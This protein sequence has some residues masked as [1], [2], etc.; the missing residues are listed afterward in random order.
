MVRYTGVQIERIKQFLRDNVYSYYADR[1]NL[2]AYVVVSDDPID[3][4]TLKD[5]K[6]SEIDVGTAWGKQW[7]SAWFK[8]VGKIPHEWKNR[9]IVAVID[10]GSEACLFDDKGNP[11]LGLTSQLHV[12]DP[13]FRKAMI[14]LRNDTL[15]GDKVS[16]LVEAAANSI[17]GIQKQAVFKEAIISTF[18]R[19][20][21]N[22]Y[23]DIFFLFDLA[24]ALPERSVR[25]AKLL[26]TL[27][28][29]I[30]IYNEDASSSVEEACNLLKEELEKPSY[31]SAPSVSAIGHAHLDVAWKWP[32]RETV[33]KAGRTFSSA[34]YYMEEYPDYRFGASQPQNY[35]FVKDNYPKLFEKIKKAV[36]ENRWELQ[37]ATWVE[38]DCNLIGGESLIR[39]VYYGKKFFLEEFGKEVNNLWLPDTFGFSPVLPQIMVKSGIKYFISQKLDW[40]KINKF[41]YNSFIWEGIDGS[42]VF[43]HFLP[44][45]TIN[46]TMRPSEL[47]S[48]MANFAEKDRS[49]RWLYLFGEGDGGGGPG[50]HH[51]EFAVRANDCE[52]LPKVKMEMAEDFFKE[53]E[54]DIENPP[55]W[56]G[57]LYLEAHQGT[58][59]TSA[60][61]KFFNRQAEFMMHNIELLLALAVVFLDYEYP[62][63]DME[64]LW[65]ILLVNQFH[66]ILPGTTIDLAYKDTLK[67]FD[68]FFKMANSILN[69]VGRDIA[70]LVGNSWQTDTG[71]IIFNTVGFKRKQIVFIP[72]SQMPSSLSFRDEGGEYISSQQGDGGTYLECTFPSYGFKIISGSNEKIHGKSLSELSVSKSHLENSLLRVEFADDGTIKRIFDKELEQ[73]IL[74]Q[75][76]KANVL[77]LY[78]DM[79]SEYDAWD[80][81]LFYRDS[82]SMESVLVELRKHEEGD[83]CVS[84]VQE[85]VVSKSKITQEILLYKDSKKIEF[86]TKVD[87]HEDHKMLKVSF[88]VNVNADSAVYDIQFGNIRRSTYH[89]TSWEKAKIEVFAHKWA[90]L[91]NG[92]VGA[93]LIN[94]SKYGYYVYKNS[95]ELTLL[96]SPTDPNPLIDRGE[97][98]FSYV[99]MPHSGD[100][101]SGEVIAEGYFFNIKPLVFKIASDKNNR[102]ISSTIAE[103]WFFEVDS[104]NVIIETVKRAEKTKGIILRV[105]EAFGVGTIATIKTPIKVKKLEETDLMENKIDLLT[106]SNEEDS[107][108]FQF[109]IKPYEI[110]TFLL[111]V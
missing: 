52:A 7:Q 15:K 106:F 53:A 6:W 48:G 70:S 99:F 74:Q 78:H 34:I 72:Y 35:Q 68:R 107:F 58:L 26:F 18:R 82:K 1:L 28:K 29:A 49:N 3:F 80:I 42:R 77:T 12:S 104:N 9:E 110:K 87:W 55:E 71:Y 108:I 4:N 21:W 75:D 32:I 57:E 17:T 23:H 20:I 103:N 13:M 51:I 27:N 63:D 41:P 95:I 66:D 10:T 37:G 22:I 100:F 111:R 73:E 16:L 44:G 69:D 65:K 98:N 46:G 93:A 61:T 102:Q 90:D 60:K 19:D 50:R 39:Q 105:Y 64:K 47:I 14:P 62:A 59:T 97:H 5:Q 96:R 31:A 88:P 101:R 85:R 25:R 45:G 2:K 109:Q 24:L 30:N 92:K 83:L 91:S 67:D 33:R 94:D 79:P 11:I 81:D 40:N 84:V 36:S 76:C 86:R 38:P 89:N 54:K 8:F 43:C 56:Y